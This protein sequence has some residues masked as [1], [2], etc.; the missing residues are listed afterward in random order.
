MAKP[1]A[2]PAM[3]PMIAHRMLRFMKISLA[4][5]MM[6]RH[7]RLRAVLALSV[8]ALLALPAGG[9]RR[10]TSTAGRDARSRASAGDSSAE[11]QQALRLALEAQEIETLLRDRRLPEAERRA[12][13]IGTPSSARH[14][15]LI[16]HLH[17]RV[18]EAIVHHRGVER[19]GEP[20]T[21]F[22][23][24]E[25]LDGHD[26]CGPSAA[27]WLR[28][29]VE[30]YR[31]FERFVPGRAHA[32]GSVVA[33]IAE[34]L[35]CAG[36]LAGARAEVARWERERGP[37]AEWARWQ[38]AWYAFAAG[39]YVATR[40]QLSSSAL[41]GRIPADVLGASRVLV[42]A[43]LD[44][45]RAVQRLC[46]PASRAT[47]A[48]KDGGEDRPWCALG[49]TRRSMVRGRLALPGVVRARVWLLPRALRNRGIVREPSQVARNRSFFHYAADVTA[50]GAYLVRDVLPGRYELVV[51]IWRRPAPSPEAA[52]GDVTVGASGQAVNVPT[53]VF[54]R[55]RESTTIPA[56]SVR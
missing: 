22:A 4:P 53:L 44:D 40:A 37:G 23:G 45:S 38:G 30:H 3:A 18:A 27:A 5:K 2:T 34:T 1:K 25:R 29:A 17:Q 14:R 8:L 42:A 7:R 12:R 52:I 49:S 21:L 43:Q 54:G 28:P 24:Q 15:F 16:G 46:T 33:R 19:P 48:T 6:P 39:D 55:P 41:V 26:L 50:D 47:P 36:D 35:A 9:C 11:E 20:F 56:G 32:R 13:R 10:P 51:K 31:R